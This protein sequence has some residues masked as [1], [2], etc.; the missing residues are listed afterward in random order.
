[1]SRPYRTWGK[2]RAPHEPIDQS[3]HIHLRNRGEGLKPPLQVLTGVW[4]GPLPNLS[5]VD[6][7]VGKVAAGVNRRATQTRN[8]TASPVTN[9]AAARPRIIESGVKIS[10][11]SV[12]NYLLA[13][14]HTYH[15]LNLRFPDFGRA[16]TQ[17]SMLVR[18][19]RRLAQ[20]I[21]VCLEWSS[22]ISTFTSSP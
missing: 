21:S 8:G 20:K 18:R 7:T 3:R 22:T 13:F 1:M 4:S 19:S 5:G 2:A 9:L 10:F 17:S 15:C 16:K 14:F 12:K 6:R 11:V